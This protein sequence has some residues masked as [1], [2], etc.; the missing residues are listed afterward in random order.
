MS[1]VT[2]LIL[3]AIAVA[4][5]GI[6]TLNQAGARNLS[7]QS[8]YAA[9]AGLAAAFREIVQGNTWTGYS[10]RPYGKE[11][12][13]WVQATAGPAGATADRPAIPGGTVYLLATATTRGGFSRRVGVLLAGTGSAAV[14]ASGYAISSGGRIDQQGGGTISGSLKSSQDIRMQGGIKVIPFQGSGRLVAT[15]DIDIGNGIKRDPSQE[16]RAGQQ[17]SIGPGN[18]A[19]DP[20]RLIFPND[21]TAAS[22]PWVADGRTENLLN[23]GEIGEVLPNPSPVSLLGLVAIGSDFEIDTA[24]GLYTIDAARTD[25]VQHSETTVSSLDL[26][27]K[28]HFFPN[29]FEISGN[30]AVTGTGTI[31]TGNGKSI[32][33]SGN[34]DLNANLLALRW[35]SQLPSGGNPR[36]RIQGNSRVTGLILAGQD[37]DIQGNFTLNGMIVA[38]NGDVHI[39]GNRRI[40]YNPSGLTLPGLQSWLSPLTPPSGPGTLGIVP[41]QPIQILSWQRL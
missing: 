31:V 7:Y 17:I 13:Y 37:V 34:Q 35:P 26:A 23:A 1:L 12:R 38:Y 16:L 40:T 22:A 21:G 5:T 11:S 30:N 28:I 9:E 15:Q 14:S 19:P 29:G 27:G 4:T 33:I 41:G 18:E 20:A 6:A 39:Q 24:T 3:I 32:E 8:V 2:I 25:V 10:N 36:I